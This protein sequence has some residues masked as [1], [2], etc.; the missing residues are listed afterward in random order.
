MAFQ[1]S[2]IGAMAAAVPVTHR[3]HGFAFGHPL[4]QLPSS[5]K[6]AVGGRTGGRS[7]TPDR[8][9][10]GGARR[11]RTATHTHMHAHA[12]TQTFSISVGS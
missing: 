11:H 12:H 3:G 2:A 10:S 7:L 5:H 8:L 4:F 9:L 1:A 6:P